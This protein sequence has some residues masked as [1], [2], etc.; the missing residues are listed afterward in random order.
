VDPFEFV[1]LLQ[2]SNL[3]AEERNEELRELAAL[4]ARQQAGEVSSRELTAALDSFLESYPL[5]AAGRREQQREQLVALLGELARG[6]N[7]G[8]V[9]RAT[10]GSLEARH[11]EF[12]AHFEGDRRRQMN[13][14]LELARAS[15]RLR[16]DDNVCL[17]RVEAQLQRAASEAARRLGPRLGADP[18]RIELSE[19]IQALEDP[20][21]EPAAPGEPALQT[22]RFELRARQLVGQPASPGLAVGPARVVFTPEELFSF[23]QGEVLVCDSLNPNMTFVAPL[24]AAIV[25]RRGGMLI[26]GAIIAREYGVPC[27]TGVPDA[28]RWI[29]TGDQLSVDGHVGI[30][31]V[32]RA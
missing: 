19:V 6:E 21:Y 2:T 25:E 8:A 22:E 7:A 29:R 10:T 14:L 18:A 5:P 28:T 3:A 32:S 27:V 1:E 24:A 4:L 30:V 11:R 9:R 12:L 26:H 17:G 15:Y 31:T 13:E 23:C 16:D 20:T